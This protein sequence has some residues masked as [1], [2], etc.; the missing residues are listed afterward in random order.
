MR[1]KIVSLMLATVMMLATVCGAAWAEEMPRKIQNHKIE[2]KVLPICFA[3][4]DTWYEMPFY[5]M[6]GVTFG[7]IVPAAVYE[8]DAATGNRI[9]IDFEPAETRFLRVILSSN[10]A[11]PAHSGGAQAAEICIY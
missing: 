6:D 1:R 10:S 7:E 11:Y 9:R 3:T 4:P 5:F 8:F 2:E